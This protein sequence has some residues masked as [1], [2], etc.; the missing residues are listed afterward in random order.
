[1]ISGDS[2]Q[3]IIQ[4]NS[5]GII[6]TRCPKIAQKVS[7]IDKKGGFSSKIA[8]IDSKYD[9]FIYF[10]VKCNSKN[11]SISFFQEYSFQEIIQ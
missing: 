3:K 1:M 2:I 4:F 10:T 6:D 9:S 7:K 8:N 5:Q 11:Y